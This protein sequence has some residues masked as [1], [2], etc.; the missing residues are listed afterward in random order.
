MT[1][2]NK[3]TANATGE[4]LDRI[5]YLIRN[6]ES[7]YLSDIISEVTDSS[8]PVYT[9]ELLNL[10]CENIDLAA[11]VPELGPAFDGEPTPTNIIAA[12]V[13]EYISDFLNNWAHE[14]NLI[15]TFQEELN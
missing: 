3:I 13:Y 14:Q 4:I 11:R 5:R 12:N 2:M 10:A 9:Y 8:V 6:K 1:K 15:E 7:D